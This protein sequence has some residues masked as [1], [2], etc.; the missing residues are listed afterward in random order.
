MPTGYPAFQ[1]RATRPARETRP[2]DI[3]LDVVQELLTAAVV[4]HL[5]AHPD[6]ESEG[7]IKAYFMAIMKQVGHRTAVTK[8]RPAI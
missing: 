3:D 7:D 1:D 5:G 4:Y 6:D 2:R 8:E